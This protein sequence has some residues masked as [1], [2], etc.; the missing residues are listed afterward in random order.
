M[1][2]F[3]GRGAGLTFSGDAV[4][5]IDEIS[6]SIERAA[7]DATDHDDASRT[8]ISGRIGG[9]IDLSLKYDSGDAGQVAL[10][11]N[12]YSDTGAEAFVYVMGDGRKISG[13]GFVTS[14]NPSGPNDDV[15]MVSCTIQISGTITEASV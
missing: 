15:G 12:I 1:A 14:W 3:H 2:K 9:T 7:L 10:K 4:G 5:G 13:S 6:A 8:Y 11:D